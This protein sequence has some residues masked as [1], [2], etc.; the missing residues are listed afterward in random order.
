M[1]GYAVGGLRVKIWVGGMEKTEPSG[2]SVWQADF[3]A[4]RTAES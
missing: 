2:A 3:R 4:L 1:V